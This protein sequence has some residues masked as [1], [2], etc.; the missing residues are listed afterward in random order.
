MKLIA[1]L[2]FLL[3]THVVFAQT[4]PF[5]KKFVEGTVFFKDSSLK[6]GQVKWF[7]HVKEKLNFRETEKD[8]AVK[9][10]P[11]EILGFSADTLRFH[12]LYNFEVYADEYALL[13]K[14]SRIKQ[15]FGEVVD[16]GRFNIY[17]VAYTGYNAISGAIQIYPNIVFENKDNPSELV[18]YPFVIRMTDKKYEKAKEKLIALF[19][20]YPE[21]VSQIQAYKK[22]N[23]FF[24]IVN[25]VKSI[26][27]R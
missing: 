12:S 24:E 1:L 3:L 21:V 8:K 4:Y 15:T 11:E 16:T 19:K 25:S 6:K 18:A 27:R 5:A 14:M 2:A 26:N 13:G 10:A 22:E 9:Y 17:L 23:D 20:D 7:P